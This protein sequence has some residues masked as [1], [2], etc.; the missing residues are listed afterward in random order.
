MKRALEPV[1]A[2]NSS[3]LSYL[4]PRLPMVLLAAFG[5]V[6]AVRIAFRLEHRPAHYLAVRLAQPNLV[7]DL[8]LL[9]DDDFDDLVRASFPSL[10][11][12]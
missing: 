9:A 10:E 7:V 6:R 2:G 12:R 11:S 8:L 5:H 3:T 1:A 4:G